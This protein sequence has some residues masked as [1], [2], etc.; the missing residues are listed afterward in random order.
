MAH[1]QVAQTAVIVCGA[2]AFGLAGAA[3]ANAFT[4]ALMLVIGG[5]SGAAACG[6]ATCGD[7]P[8]VTLIPAGFFALI[9]L[10]QSPWSLAPAIC[11]SVV[12]GLGLGAAALFTASLLSVLQD[13][14]DEDN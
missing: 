11:F 13:R 9:A 14:D 4:I 3:Y 1:K 8:F 2:I 7:S 6:I 10:V 5:I 12:L